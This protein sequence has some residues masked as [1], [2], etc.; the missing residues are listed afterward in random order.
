MTGGTAGPTTTTPVVVEATGPTST[1]SMG[2][3]T[4]SL[5]NL[6]ESQLAEEEKNEKLAGLVDMGSDFLLG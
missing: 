6:T 1:D 2:S 3:V 4:K 5:A